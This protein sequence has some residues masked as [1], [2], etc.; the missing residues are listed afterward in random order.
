MNSSI[1]KRDYGK[2]YF[3]IKE[4]MEDSRSSVS[5]TVNHT[6][7]HTYHEKIYFKIKRL[8]EHARSSV[9]YNVNLTLLHTYHEIG[10]AIV[11][12]GHNRLGRAEYGKSLMNKL[13]KAL[14]RDFGIGFSKTNLFNMRR[15]YLN[16]PD[17]C[18]LSGKLTW[19]HYCELMTIKNKNKR[20]FYQ[21]EAES[22]N[23]S[24][25][26]LKR[27]IRTSL[28]ERLILTKGND[29]R[30]K[31]LE[32][33]EDG[34]EIKSPEDFIKS[35]YVFEFL[36]IPEDKT[37]LETN[38]LDVLSN[39]I[40]KFLLELGRGFI[41]L[42]SRKRITLGN[43]NYYVDMVL[44]NKILNSYVLIELKSGKLIPETVGQLNMY[45][46]YYKTE[47]N[48]E[49]DAGPIGIILCDDKDNIQAEYALKGLSNQIFVSR[50]TL[51]IPKKEDLEQQVKTVLEEYHNNN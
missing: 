40:E 24:V 5:Y 51:Y 17:F 2:T 42:E 8:M 46:N 10:R 29:I 16:Y 36:G 22:A 7:L 12:N 44:Y 38:L 4:L 27:Q 13:S 9:S 6:F 23:W 50:Y 43:N 25:R 48:G 37:I 49:H 30:K 11:E 3:K 26:E 32:L 47:I 34:N 39:N 18:T 28:Y 1:E 35:L 31:I 15:F 41:Y 20:S 21:K 45:L 14:T 33:A 19:S